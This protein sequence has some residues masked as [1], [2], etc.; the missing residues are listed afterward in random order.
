MN[1]LEELFRIRRNI[2]DSVFSKMVKSPKYLK[3]IYLSLHP[4]DSEVREEDL[5]LITS[6]PVFLGGVIQDCCFTVRRKKAIFIEVQSTPC[7]LLP[8]RMICYWAHNIHKIN[9]EYGKFQYSRNGTKMPEY[10]FWTI[11]VGEA[12]EKMTENLYL[13]GEKELKDGTLNISLKV[14]TEYNTIGYVNEYCVFSRIY[15]E[16]LK[17]YRGNQLKVVKETLKEALEQEILK[18]FLEEHMEEVAEIMS[19]MD[20]YNFEMYLKGLT[21]NAENKGIEIGI[22]RGRVEGLE[23]GIERGRAVEKNNAASMFKTILEKNG[24]SQSEI[25]QI[26]KSYRMM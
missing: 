14:K 20:E 5:H 17:K 10:E 16:N 26:I 15:R 22:E 8:E 24:L 25:N 12:A 19:A 11:Y 1:N 23:E 7:S 3:R 21:E 18:E 13:G 2:R 6:E 4:E 9:P